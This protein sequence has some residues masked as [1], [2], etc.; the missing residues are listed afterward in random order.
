MLE[1]RPRLV[2]GTREW[3]PPELLFQPLSQPRCGNGAELP[4][5]RLFLQPDLPQPE[6]CGL[7]PRG[8]AFQPRAPRPVWPSFLLPTCWL[9]LPPV[10]PWSGLSYGP[11]HG[12]VFRPRSQPRSWHACQ[13][14]PWQPPELLPRLG[15]AI[16]CGFVPW[17]MLQPVRSL[18]TWTCVGPPVAAPLRPALGIFSKHPPCRVFVPV[19]PLQREIAALPQS[20]LDSQP[21][22]LRFLI[23][24][25]RFPSRGPSG[26]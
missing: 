5:G 12:P 26:S 3:P 4:P 15:V 10:Q 18:R 8:Q 6:T 23:C 11:P 21:V 7:L 20:L 16:S 9:L 2:G 1:Q 25:E 13:R 14:R 24:A 17:L 22:P 19:P